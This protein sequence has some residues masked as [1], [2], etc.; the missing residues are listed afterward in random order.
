MLGADKTLLGADKTLAKN[1][2]INTKLISLLLN[3]SPL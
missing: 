1:N 2:K 3:I